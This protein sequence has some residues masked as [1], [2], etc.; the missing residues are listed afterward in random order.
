MKGYLDPTAT[1]QRR[2]RNRLAISRNTTS[3][4]TKHKARHW[5]MGTTHSKSPHPSSPSVRLASFR[6]AHNRPPHPFCPTQADP[7]PERTPTATKDHEVQSTERKE[8]R[9]G[10]LKRLPSTSAPT[11]KAA[12]IQPPRPSAK[13]PIHTRKEG[14]ARAL[15]QCGEPVIGVAHT[16]FTEDGRMPTDATL[17]GFVMGVV[18][19]GTN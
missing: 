15:N 5:P 12:P 18:L 10:A 4:G 13:A 14:A 9:S 17:R 7:T 6:A 3:R 16:R 19:S 1:S 11:R 8:R 2:W